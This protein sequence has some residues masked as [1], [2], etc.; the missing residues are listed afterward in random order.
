MNPKHLSLLDG[1]NEPV[2]FM[3][4]QKFDESLS[5]RAYFLRNVMS[6]FE[7]LLLF[8]RA[9]RQGK[10]EL[11]L[12]FIE[13]MLPYFF[14]HDQLNYAR[15]SPA[16]LAEMYTLHETDPEIWDYLASGNF[17]VNKNTIPFCAIG[18]DH[19]LGQ[20]NREM[21]VLGGV[22]GLLLNKDALNQFALIAP[23]LNKICDEFCVANNIGQNSRTEQYQHS[24]S[25]NNHILSNTSKLSEKP[26]SFDITFDKNENVYNII[27]KSVLPEKVQKQ[28]LSYKLT[29]YEL[30]QSFVSNRIYGG[31]SIWSPLKKANTLTFKSSCKTLKT[32]IEGKV[33]VLKEDGWAQRCLKKIRRLCNAC[34]SYLRNVRGSTSGDYEFSVVPRSLFCHER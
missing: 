32:K 29:G 14:A 13:L 9:T 1:F 34:I 18:A 33:V 31:L 8:T 15:L 27:A 23:E 16:Y 7:I 21:K 10:G 12:K 25:F 19:A 5:N 22:K 11:H 30:Y 2:I 26:E 3:K 17:S 20:Q 6:M 24:I 4:M 28:V